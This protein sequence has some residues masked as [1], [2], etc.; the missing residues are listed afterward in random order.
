MHRALGK[1]VLLGTMDAVEEV[2]CQE[3]ACM[4]N[5]CGCASV[6]TRLLMRDP[7]SADAYARMP[8]FVAS[9]LLLH[10]KAKAWL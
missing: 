7:Y 4:A 5:R 8:L 6:V 1:Y 9:Y 10:P 3:H 2:W